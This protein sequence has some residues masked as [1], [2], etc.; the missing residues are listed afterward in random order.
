MR[1]F[2]VWVEVECY[3]EDGEVGSE[4]LDQQF[5]V[6]AEF[7]TAREALAWAEAMHTFGRRMLPELI[8]ITGGSAV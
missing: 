2:K 7:L 1:V 5:G 3:D 4:D 6:T 8:A